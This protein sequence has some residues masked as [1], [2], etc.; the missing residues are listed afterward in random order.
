L[1]RAANRSATISAI[2]VKWAEISS[3]ARSER[4]HASYW[5]FF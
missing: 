4:R 5:Q 1:R 3:M 2:L